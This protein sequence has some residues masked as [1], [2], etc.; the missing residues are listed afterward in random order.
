VPNTRLIPHWLPGRGG[1]GEGRG[2]GEGKMCPEC[3]PTIKIS[4]DIRSVLLEIRSGQRQ[5]D[6]NYEYVM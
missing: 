1:E 6:T 5:K 3:R 2:G 4:I